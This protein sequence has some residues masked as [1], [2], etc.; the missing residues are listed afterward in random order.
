[1]SRNTNDRDQNDFGNNMVITRQISPPWNS[2]P[3]AVAEVVTCGIATGI[4]CSQLYYRLTN[5]AL[6]PKTVGI[7][8]VITTSIYIYLRDQDILTAGHVRHISFSTTLAAL[9]MEINEYIKELGYAGNND[10]T[11]ID[12]N[13]LPKIKNDNDKPLWRL[14]L[15]VVTKDN[16]KKQ[17]YLSGA[18]HSSAASS[19]GDKVVSDIAQNGLKGLAGATALIASRSGEILKGYRSQATNIVGIDGSVSPPSPSKAED[20]LTVF[21]PVPEDELMSAATINISE[22]I[23]SDVPKED[24]SML[25]QGKEMTVNALKEVGNRVENMV[26]TKPTLSEGPV[27]QLGGSSTV[28]KEFF[29][30]W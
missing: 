2:S 30:L 4:S 9:L 11:P 12:E 18:L 25:L 15:E 19:V 29:S 26:S 8:S 16:K 3:K 28:D 14:I 1:M 17:Y 22:K 6:P 21:I 24:D 20:D 13:N 27:S 10:S 7:I 23:V 5:H